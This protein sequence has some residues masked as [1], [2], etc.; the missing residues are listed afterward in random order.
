V[1]SSVLTLVF[2]F[3]LSG[4][5]HGYAAYALP[6]QGSTFDRFGRYLVFFL[7]QP[8]GIVIEDVV[9]R[10]YKKYIGK[11]K[12]EE[13]D[14]YMVWKAILGYV[15]V[16][17]WSMFSGNILLDAYLKTEMG[18]VGSQPTVVEPIFRMLWKRE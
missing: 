8:F 9:I 3:G 5:Y 2:T 16:F 11:R 7:I 17:C 14:S 12:G 15:W 10:A 4:L 13:K 1:L 18:L 6:M